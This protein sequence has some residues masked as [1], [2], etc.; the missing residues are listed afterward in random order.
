MSFVTSPFMYLTVDAWQLPKTG[1]NIKK[2]ALVHLPKHQYAIFE[3]ALGL[4]SK[5]KL[6]SILQFTECEFFNIINF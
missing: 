1:M 3:E 2:V 6:P 4:A 5:F